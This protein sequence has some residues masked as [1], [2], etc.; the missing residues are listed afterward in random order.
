MMTGKKRAIRWTTVNGKGEN[1]R[2]AHNELEGEREILKKFSFRKK[3]LSVS[4]AAAGYYPLIIMEHNSGER[5]C[6]GAELT[7]QSSG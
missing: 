4:A 5:T 6:P 1:A 3:V 2:V 7:A